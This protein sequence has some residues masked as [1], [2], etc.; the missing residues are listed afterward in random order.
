MG[1]AVLEMLVRVALSVDVRPAQPDRGQSLKQP[2]SPPNWY[3]PGNLNGCPDRIN[4]FPETDV[5]APRA[6]SGRSRERAPAEAAEF[7]KLPPQLRKQLL[8]YGARWTRA[9]FEPATEDKAGS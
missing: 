4:L 8:R 7:L 3:A 6:K 9:M 1:L 2:E 5:P